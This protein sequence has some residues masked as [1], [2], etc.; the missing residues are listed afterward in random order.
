MGP[1]TAASLA[2]ARVTSPIDLD[3]D[4]VPFARDS[5]AASSRS[6]L[7]GVDPATVRKAK[8][9]AVPGAHY[10]PAGHVTGTERSTG[11]RAV[12]V[13]G[14]NSACVEEKG[15]RSARNLDGE[16]GFRPKLAHLGDFDSLCHARQGVHDPACSR[17]E[18]L[19]YAR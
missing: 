7:G 6:R 18:A 14:E 3:P 13:Q 16:A 17:F 15:D 9:P 10:D 4:V 19:L 11:V 12:V 2:P 8:S 1:P 5:I